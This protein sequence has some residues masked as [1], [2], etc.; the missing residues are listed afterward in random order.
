MNWYREYI[1]AAKVQPKDDDFSWTYI[2]VPEEVMK[3]HRSFTKTIEKNDLYIEKAKG[4]DYHYGIEDDPHITAKYGFSF[5]DPKQVIEV[6]DGAKGGNVSVEAID[7]FEKD[8]YDVLVIKCKSSA[9][10]KIHAKL[11]D[12]LGIED[13]YPVFKPHVTIAYFKTGKAKKYKPLAEKH[14]LDKGIEFEFDKVFFEDTEDKTT[15]ID[16]E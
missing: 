13:K 7:V 11:T 5:D 6:L 10:A 16:I 8:E 1:T 12:D 3:L 14:F 2:E 4:G 15:Q 9:L